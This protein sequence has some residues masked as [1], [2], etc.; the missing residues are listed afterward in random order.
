M[1]FGNE[2]AIVIE[3]YDR[4]S[5]AQLATAA[6]AEAAVAAADPDET[7][8]RVASMTEKLADAVAAVRVRAESDGLGHEIVGRLAQRISV[9]AEECLARLDR[10]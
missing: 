10:P 9:R 2:V 3:R 7:I 1:R 4:V 8:A 5:T 6:A